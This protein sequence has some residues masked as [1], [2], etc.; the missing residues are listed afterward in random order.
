MARKWKLSD[1][2]IA[3]HRVGRRVLMRK[4]ALTWLAHN[5]SQSADAAMAYLDTTL[6]SMVGLKTWDWVE[7][8]QEE[9]ARLLV[10][11]ARKLRV[12]KRA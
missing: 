5:P 11:L 3:A 10:Q 1:I 6:P 12:R 8:S 7:L 4:D 2:I 9:R